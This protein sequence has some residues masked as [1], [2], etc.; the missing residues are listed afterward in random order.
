MFLWFWIFTF[1]VVSIS[2]CEMFL[3]NWCKSV[4][5][6]FKYLSWIV[7]FVLK[8]CWRENLVSDIMQ[9]SIVVKRNSIQNSEFMVPKIIHVWN[10]FVRFQVFVM[11]YDTGFINLWRLIY[12]VP[13]PFI[14]YLCMVYHENVTP[15]FDLHS[16]CSIGL[17]FRFVLI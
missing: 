1:L 11:Y 5:C 13:S 16:S 12:I 10:F 7:K 8:K 2:M 15:M 17:V 14:S 6:L 4:L 9:N 3:F